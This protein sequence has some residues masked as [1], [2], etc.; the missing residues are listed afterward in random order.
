[1]HKSESEDAFYQTETTF[2]LLKV[3]VKPAVYY[4]MKCCK[5]IFDVF[6]NSLKTFGLSSHKLTPH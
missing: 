3:R 1:M 4:K 6:M 2:L 5:E